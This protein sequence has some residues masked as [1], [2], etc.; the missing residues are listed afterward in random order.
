MDNIRIGI[1][2][3]GRFA[4]QHGRIWRQMP[5]VEVVAVCDRNPDQFPA[6]K[7]WFPKA[8]CYLDWE[9]MFEQEQLDAVDIL[10]PEHLHVEPVLAAFQAGVHVFV[11]KPLAHT[12]K[13]ANLLL[14]AAIK[15]DRLLVTGHVLRFDARYAAVKQELAEGRMGAIRSIYAKR[16]NGKKFFPIYNRINPVFILGI[17]D[18]DLMHWYMEDQVREVTAVGT[19]GSGHPASPADVSWAML[20]FTKGGVGIL[21]N[22]WLL[23]DGAPSFADVRME[24]TA[25]EGMIEIKE[26]ESGVVYAGNTKTDLL[27]LHSGYEL[28]GRMMGPLAAEL[29]HFAHCVSSGRQSNILRTTDALR[30]VQVAWAV[31]QSAELGRPILLSALESLESGN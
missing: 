22:N 30:A 29:E 7:E 27:S 18:I 24:I 31:Q 17:H 6:F 5:N 8:E 20:T 28:H 13:D 2:G 25:S 16:N 23:P 15:Y 1:I 21:E 12:P 19:S 4:A 26:P 14:Q 9:R 10:T 3:L 11:E